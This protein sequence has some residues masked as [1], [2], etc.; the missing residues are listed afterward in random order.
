[1]YFNNIKSSVVEI[2]IE[3]Y[4]SVVYHV[5]NLDSNTFLRYEHSYY[6]FI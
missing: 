2:H 5:I 6:D 4:Y 3:I 1:M